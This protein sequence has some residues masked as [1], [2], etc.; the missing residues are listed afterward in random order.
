MFRRIAICLCVLMLAG[1]ASAQITVQLDKT[2]PVV[3]VTSPAPCGQLIKSP[4]A[5]RGIAIDDESGISEVKMSLVRDAFG[6]NAHGWQTWTGY[7]W[8]PIADLEDRMNLAVNATAQDGWW[9]SVERMP[10]IESGTLRY[11]EHIHVFVHATNG[12]GL[13]AHWISCFLVTKLQIAQ[14]PSELPEE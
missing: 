11:G 13:E 4:T 3:V 7:G 14:P 5:V 6:P 10:S 9:V 1:V 12:H 8:S 2:P